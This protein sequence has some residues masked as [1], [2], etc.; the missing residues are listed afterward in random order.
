MVILVQYMYEEIVF[1]NAEDSIKMQVC[2]HAL[3]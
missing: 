3:G 2:Y 1:N